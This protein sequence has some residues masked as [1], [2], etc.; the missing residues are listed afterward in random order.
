MTPTRPIR[1]PWPS[2]SNFSREVIRQIQKIA[3]GPGLIDAPGA[4]SVFNQ[5]GRSVVVQRPAGGAQ[6]AWFHILT[7]DEFQYAVSEGRLPETAEGGIFCR[8]KNDCEGDPDVYDSPAGWGV[9]N[10]ASDCQ[11][12]RASSTSPELVY[13]PQLRDELCGASSVLDCP[14]RIPDPIGD[15]L[16]EDRLVAAWY[17]KT[18][19]RW[20]AIFDFNDGDTWDTVWFCDPKEPI[21]EC[22]WC[23][24]TE[25][26]FMP[27]CCLFD[28]RAMRINPS[29]D[30]CEANNE[31]FDVWIFCPD[32]DLIDVTA[33]CH[34]ARLIQPQYRTQ[35]EL[36]STGGEGLDIWITDTRPVYHIPVCKCGCPKDAVRLTFYTDEAGYE[37]NLSGGWEVVNPCS[38]LDGFSVVLSDVTTVFIGDDVNCAG[39]STPGTDTC[40]Y[41]YSGCFCATWR[42]PV[43]VFEVEV[44]VDKNDGNPPDLELLYV[45]PNC[46]TGELENVWVAAAFYHGGGDGYDLLEDTT[47]TIAT[48]P[49]PADKVSP[50]KC[51][52]LTTCS[53]H[54]GAPSE[55]VWQECRFCYR[56]QFDC[57][58]GEVGSPT[59]THMLPI[60]HPAYLNHGSNESVGDDI[61]CDF[62]V[63][64]TDGDGAS[65]PVNGDT[66]TDSL[67][68]FVV[69][70]T[71]VVTSGSFGTADAAGYI[72]LAGGGGTTFLE[73]GAGTFD[74]PASCTITQ[75]AGPVLISDPNVFT[76]V[77]TTDCEGRKWYSMDMTLGESTVDPVSTFGFPHL[78]Y[79]VFGGCCQGVG[80]SGV[81]EAN[82]TCGCCQE[83][84]GCLTPCNPLVYIKMEWNCRFN[85]TVLL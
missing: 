24:E 45:Q 27:T 56:F 81:A 34:P 19:S 67:A 70:D 14:D 21:N 58:N 3:R 59:I 84:P 76:P 80:D 85:D 42:V 7:D 32:I 30:F 46:E 57:C 37:E 35:Y 31:T 68:N 73:P 40:R 51:L 72:T 29:C 1:Y 28:G 16:G 8:D 53:V 6:L 33:S 26:E 38:P 62:F 74:T 4:A 11:T 66:L 2:D 41:R 71:V 10:E 25:E 61:E 13:F 20:E 9:R 18:N 60:G 55:V 39:E 36:Q 75:H 79:H 22:A 48:P 82:A 12:D 83:A 65:Q 77:A 15:L 17:N 52:I 54:T 43:Y 69:V 47:W 63:H 23:V 78:T 64:F 5:P 49:T 44:M 50:E